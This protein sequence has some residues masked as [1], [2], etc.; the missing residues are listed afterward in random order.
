MSL[1]LSVF[2]SEP[3]APRSTLSKGSVIHLAPTSAD[4]IQLLDTQYKYYKEEPFEYL[5]IVM[6]VRNRDMT[7]V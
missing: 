5:G 6:Q 3:P 4:P 1:R 7:Q 2:T